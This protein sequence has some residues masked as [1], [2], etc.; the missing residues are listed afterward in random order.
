MRNPR[1]PAGLKFA[2][3]LRTVLLATLCLATAGC[4]TAQRY[5]AAQGWRQSQCERLVDLAQRNLCVSRASM[6]YDAFKH[7]TER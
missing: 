6:D 1:A 3:Q 5:H 2:S 4:T 7:Q